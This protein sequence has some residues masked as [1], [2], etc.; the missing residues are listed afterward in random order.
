MINIGIFHREGLKPSMLHH[1]ALGEPV[2]PL[3]LG[4]VCC[5]LLFHPW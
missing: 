5:I 2:L 1:A 3:E 4:G